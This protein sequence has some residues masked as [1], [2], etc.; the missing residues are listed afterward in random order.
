M[1][2]PFPISLLLACRYG[3]IT[4]IEAA[5]VAKLLARELE[6]DARAGFSVEVPSIGDI[7]LEASGHVSWS[8]GRDVPVERAGRS[9][10]R[11]LAVLVGEAERCGDRA[12]AALMFALARA[13][14]D[15]ALVPLETL[16]DLYLIVDR[17]APADPLPVTAAFAE[18]VGS[19]AIEIRPQPIRTVSDLRRARRDRGVSLATI[20]SET[21]IPLTLLREL[22]WGLFESWPP[23]DQTEASLRAYARAAGLRPK[24]VL[25]VVRGPAMLPPPLEVR[26][27]PVWVAA[28]AVVVLSG[29]AAATWVT[30]APTAQSAAVQPVHAVAPVNPEETF[31]RIAP[32][33]TAAPEAAVA[34]AAA[35]IPAVTVVREPAVVSAPDQ[36]R[37]EPPRRK[38][39]PASRRAAMKRAAARPDHAVVA[40]RE[41]ERKRQSFWK[42]PLFIIKFGGS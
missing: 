7:R 3:R 2:Q 31:I 27:V 9:L 23:G 17:I 14:D 40:R 35:V 29:A 32:G 34:P 22:E 20:A 21:G 13:T 12:P 33:P 39:A 1:A 15:E 25:A 37:V 11:I 42:K 28:C 30:R 38:A 6:R 5:A 41:P 8:H 24:A 18:R 16:H 36:S 4:I 19:R 26:G 10:A